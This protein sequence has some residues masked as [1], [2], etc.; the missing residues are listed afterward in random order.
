MKPKEGK[1]LSG[2]KYITSIQ[3]LLTPLWD[4]VYSNFPAD[5]VREGSCPCLK[6]HAHGHQHSKLLHIADRLQYKLKNA[7]KD[8]SS[9]QIDKNRHKVVS[10]LNKVDFWLVM[11]TYCIHSDM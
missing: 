5:H 10:E 7:P 4:R 2:G 8:A 6:S 1:L 11:T 3:I 9:K